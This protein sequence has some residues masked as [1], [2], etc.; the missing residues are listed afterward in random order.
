[1][2]YSNDF[3]T[4]VNKLEWQLGLIPLTPHLPEQYGKDRWVDIIKES[5]LVTFSR[6]Y[7]FKIKY[8]V[9]N[10]TTVKKGNIYYLKDEYVG[11]AK[12]L[13]IG[14]IDWG[15]FGNDNLSLSQVGPY[16]YYSPSYYGAFPATIDQMI[17][18]KLGADLASNYNTGIYI[19]YH[20]PN[21]FEVK[22]VG[23]LNINL[24]SFIID[25]LVQHDN[26]ST[27]SPTKM[28]TFEKLAKADVAMFL[29]QNL[30]YYDGLETV[31]AQV[32]MKLSE[33]QDE[34]NKRDQVIETLEN[35]YVSAS[36]DAIPYILTV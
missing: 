17:G 4:L 19:E 3:T 9:N 2:A 30:K 5:S 22:G 28:E 26:L 31:F 20:D 8:R 25:V 35:S 34:A 27:I 11:N 29:Y 36:N 23:N 10:E 1:M 33:L 7:P 32:D 16:G 21:A 6:Y 14:D 15:D 24:E 12:I 13:G 18:F